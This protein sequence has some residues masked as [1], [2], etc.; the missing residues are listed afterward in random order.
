MG[1]VYVL[2][3]TVVYTDFE[4]HYETFVLGVFDNVD[5]ADKIRIAKT[6]EFVN[7]PKS[8]MLYDAEDVKRHFGIKPVE[9]NKYLS[10]YER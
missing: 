4:T 5:D 3:E 9:P 2:T 1:N 10:V 8:Y 6:L 7:K